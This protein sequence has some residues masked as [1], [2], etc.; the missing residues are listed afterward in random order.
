LVTKSRY[1]LTFAMKPT[2]WKLTEN[3]DEIKGNECVTMNVVNFMTKL[4]L[5]LTSTIE[6]F[7]SLISY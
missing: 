1:F 4:F 6:I 7:V 5:I 2:K 3:N